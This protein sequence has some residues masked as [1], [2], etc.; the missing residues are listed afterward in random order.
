MLAIKLTARSQRIRMHT[1][2]S[3]PLTI[4]CRHV[5]QGLDGAGK[6]TLL[7]RL[8]VQKAVHTIPTIGF[9]AENVS[10]PIFICIYICPLF[11]ALSFIRRCM[12]RSSESVLLLAAMDPT[13]QSVDHSSVFT[14][15]THACRNVVL[16]FFH[17]LCRLR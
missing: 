11:C 3:G 16:H 17:C 9:N 10:Q 13:M 5:L 4:C 1:V 7:Y 2:F 12:L 15:P 14:H 8:K 6:T